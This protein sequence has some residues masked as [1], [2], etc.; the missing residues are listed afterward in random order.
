MTLGAC[1][2]AEPVPLGSLLATSPQPRARCVK[3]PRVELRLW[4]IVLV[5]TEALPIGEAFTGSCLT[6][7]GHCRA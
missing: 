3:K 4:E 6:H 5:V 2:I 1:G 7:I